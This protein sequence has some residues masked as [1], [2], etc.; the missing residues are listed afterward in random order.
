M[1][2]IGFLISKHKTMKETTEKKNLDE[3]DIKYFKSMI[4]DHT[5]KR[6]GIKSFFF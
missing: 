5:V 1:M 4:K 6:I 3:L 2:K